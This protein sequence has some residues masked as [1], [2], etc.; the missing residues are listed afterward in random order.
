MYAQFSF[1]GGGG[2]EYIT[3]FETMHSSLSSEYFSL[4]L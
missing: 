2:E 4:L 1:G 3:A